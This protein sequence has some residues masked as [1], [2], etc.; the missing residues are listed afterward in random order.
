MWTGRKLLLYV[1]YIILV[2]ALGSA[3]ILA[4]TNQKPVNKPLAKAP[5]HSQAAKTN[6]D[7]PAPVK[8][9]PTPASPSQTTP[10][11]DTTAAAAATKAAIAANQSAT[12]TQLTNTGP[13]STIALFAV[14]T[15][16]AIAYSYRRQLQNI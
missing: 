9:S 2:V 12:N 10:A 16:L 13:G 7:Q 3:I 14:V 1:L 4:F 11:S 6:Q 15:V 8:P 5:T